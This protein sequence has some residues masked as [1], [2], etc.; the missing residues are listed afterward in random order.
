MRLRE[1]RI[2]KFPGGACPQTPLG[3]QGPSGLAT[4][5][6]LNATSTFKS[7]ENTVLKQLAET[8]NTL[9][10][11]GSHD[12]SNAELIGYN[13]KN[14]RYRMTLKQ[15][16]DLAMFKFCPPKSSIFWWFKKWRKIVFLSM[17][18]KC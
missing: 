10:T 4:P 3:G 11:L 7:C 6:S 9:C 12:L 13:P 14:H 15:F 5:T 16:V 1:S 8:S 18:K 17:K 2:S